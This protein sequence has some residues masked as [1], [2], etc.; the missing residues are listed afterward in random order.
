[1]QL[2]SLQGGTCSIKLKAESMITLN[3]VV[4]TPVL[5]E[6]PLLLSVEPGG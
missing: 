2:S 1:M 6:D 4:L 5:E 3:N